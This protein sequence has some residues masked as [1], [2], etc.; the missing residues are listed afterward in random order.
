MN[1]GT[2]NNPNPRLLRFTSAEYPLAAGLIVDVPHGLLG[3]PQSVT[4]VL[5]C[6]VANNGLAVGD[7]QPATDFCP[8]GADFAAF[9]SRANRTNVSFTM[10]SGGTMRSGGLSSGTI[11][12]GL[13]LANYTAKCYAVYTP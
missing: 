13:T 1:R 8:V 5:V 10:N 3:T 7:E 9:T 4:W 2:L 11:S 12:A 6:K